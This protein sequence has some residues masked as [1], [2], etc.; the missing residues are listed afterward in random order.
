MLAQKQ[1]K[2]ADVSRFELTFD[3]TWFDRRS[4]P[5]RSHFKSGHCP[6]LCQPGARADLVERAERI[7]RTALTL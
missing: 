4:L 1:A 2:V 7:A 3:Q 6:K 5:I